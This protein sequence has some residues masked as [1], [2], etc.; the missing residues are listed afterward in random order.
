MNVFDLLAEVLAEANVP[1]GDDVPATIDADVRDEFI[2]IR[3]AGET[4]AV[5]KDGSAKRL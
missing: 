3:V 4:I 1:N 2:Y 5:G